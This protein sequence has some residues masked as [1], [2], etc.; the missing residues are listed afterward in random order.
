MNHDMMEKCPGHNFFFL[1]ELCIFLDFDISIKIEEFLNF[2][3]AIF[4]FKTHF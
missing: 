2:Q 4:K 1:L 3:F